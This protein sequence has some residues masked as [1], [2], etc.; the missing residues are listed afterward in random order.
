MTFF[1]SSLVCQMKLIAPKDHKGESICDIEILALLPFF[2]HYISVHESYRYVNMWSR[3]GIK[4]P[5]MVPKCLRTL[6]G[7][8]VPQR[9]FFICTQKKKLNETSWPLRKP[10]GVSTALLVMFRYIVSAIWISDN[11]L[12]LPYRISVSDLKKYE[13]KF[14]ILFR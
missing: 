3:Y 5:K 9:H 11:R 8:Y 14:Q 12:F 1:C 10:M 7:A 13:L 4:C 2:K 6:I